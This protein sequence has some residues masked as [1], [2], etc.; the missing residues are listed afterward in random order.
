MV[1]DLAAERGVVVHGDNAEA[2]PRLPS[3][4]FQ[5]IYIDPPFNTGIIQQRRTLRKTSSGPEPRAGFLSLIHI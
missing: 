5:L 1:I 4:S 2:L 3:E